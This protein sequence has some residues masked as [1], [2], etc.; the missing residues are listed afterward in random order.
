MGAPPRLPLLKGGS[1]PLA[2]S[3][4]ADTA[5]CAL[6]LALLAIQ[7]QPGRHGSAG[8]NFG[9]AS[10]RAASDQSSKLTF[11]SGLP[12][13][14]DPRSSGRG[15]SDSEPGPARPHCGAPSFGQ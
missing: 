12:A 6:A 5:T 3:D 15:D 4:A 7:W 11:Q 2:A 13:W 1:T 8:A 9:L 10:S 14:P